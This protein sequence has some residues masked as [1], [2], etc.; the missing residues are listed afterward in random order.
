LD[1]YARHGRAEARSASSR[2]VSRPSTSFPAL[3]SQDVDARDKP[4]HDDE[5]CRI[6]IRTANAPAHKK[7]DP[8]VLFFIR[9]ARLRLSRRSV[10]IVMMM[11]VMV[12]TPT[13]RY[14]DPGNDPAIGVMMVV[15]MMVM[16]LHHLDISIR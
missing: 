4:G 2:Q 11:V 14:D 8:K 6:L 9:A 1:L 3:T 13:R 7:Q 10:V 12:M 16:K 15:V 5:R